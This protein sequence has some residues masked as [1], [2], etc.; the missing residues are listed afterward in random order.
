MA[1]P[2]LPSVADGRSW[3]VQAA[4]SGGRMQA[5]TRAGMVMCF[6]FILLLF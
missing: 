3:L 4:S 6:V 5:T 1:R 2:W